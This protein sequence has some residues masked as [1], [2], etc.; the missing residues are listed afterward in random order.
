MSNQD[1]EE[2]DTTAHRGRKC[3]RLEPVSPAPSGEPAGA[4]T[5]GG[6]PVLIPTGWKDLV[7]KDGDSYCLAPEGAVYYWRH[8]AR[9]EGDVE[10]E[11]SPTEYSP[12][13]RGR[14]PKGER[15]REKILEALEGYSA[16]VT[17]PIGLDDGEPVV[18]GPPKSR[19]WQRYRG[20]LAASVQ[21]VNTTALA[22]VLGQLFWDGEGNRADVEPV[23]EDWVRDWRRKSR[24]NSD[25]GRSAASGP[26]LDLV[27]RADRPY[28]VVKV[29]ERL[30]EMPRDH[31]DKIS[32]ILVKLNAIHANTETLVE[33]QAELLAIVRANFLDDTFAATVDRLVDD[34]LRDAD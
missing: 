24:T 18:I 8:D 13:P 32:P 29:P 15:R 9:L 16:V 11:E 20:G 17:F 4:S 33:G 34:A 5:V 27:I 22:E 14:P 31:M 10:D 12:P 30:K 23:A 21:G 25:S 19:S 28:V 6:A 3:A 2:R 1:S 26:A 7:D